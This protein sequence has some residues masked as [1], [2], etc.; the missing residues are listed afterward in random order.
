[1]YVEK[2]NPL[3]EIHKL[4]KSQ[5]ILPRLITINGIV[6]LAVTF[7]IVVAYLFN[8]SDIEMK[9]LIVEYLGIPADIQNLVYRPWTL[10]TY[11]FLHINFWHIL[12]NMLWLFWFGKIFLEFLNRKQLLV[13]YIM[14]GLAGAAL[15]MFAY[16]VFPAFSEVK[17]FSHALGASAAVMAIVTAISFY[18]PNYTIHLLLFG[19]VKIVYVAIILFVLDFFMIRSDNSGEARRLVVLNLSS[20]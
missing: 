13:T 7:V 5:S 11:M 15:Y 20:V 3:D 19:K 12:F 16:N 1:M 14:G 6:W 17:T 18:V 10:V 9:G 8:I 4:C 2:Q